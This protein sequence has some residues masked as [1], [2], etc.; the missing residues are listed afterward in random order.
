MGLGGLDPVGE[1]QKAASASFDESLADLETRILATFQ[2]LQIG[3]EGIDLDREGLRGPSS[4][5]TY[6]VNDDSMSDHL[7]HLLMGNRNI[8]LNAGAGLMWPLLALWIALRKLT[9]RRR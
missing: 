2:S 8:G 1:F 9:R 5:W 6:L 4:T 3:P 7:A